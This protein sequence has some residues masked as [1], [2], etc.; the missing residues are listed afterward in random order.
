MEELKKETRNLY[1][2]MCAFTVANYGENVNFFSNNN[3]IKCNSEE[4]RIIFLYKSAFLVVY[5]SIPDRE[6]G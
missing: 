1:K 4:K 6:E 2:K 5:H 3:F